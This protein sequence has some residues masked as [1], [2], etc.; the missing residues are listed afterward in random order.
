[1][2]PQCRQ[3]LPSK[4]CGVCAKL[5]SPEK[6]DDKQLIG[7]NMRLQSTWNFRNSWLRHPGQGLDPHPYLFGSLHFNF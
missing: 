3:R 7:E 5:R 1:M 6:I 2:V 4:V